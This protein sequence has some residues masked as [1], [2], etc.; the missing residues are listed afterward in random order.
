MALGPG[1]SKSPLIRPNA[2]QRP[3]VEL[4]RAPHNVSTRFS[5]QYRMNW[6]GHDPDGRIDRYLYSI[7]PPPPTTAVPEPESVWVETARSEQLLTFTATQPDTTVR[8]GEKGASDFHTFVLK[9]VD[10]GGLGGPL[11][12]EPLIRSF[13]TYTVAPMVQIIEP[14]PSSR[15]RNYIPPSVRIHWTGDDPDG[16]LHNQKPVQYK[17]IML[18]EE[19]P[20]PFSIA[21]TNPDSVR[22]Y[23]APRNWATWDST[24]ADTLEK[25]YTNLV[26]GKNY[27]F[28]IIAIDEAGAY[29]PVFN[30]NQNMLNMR[31]TFA[32]QGGPTLTV[33]SDIFFYTYDPPVYSTLPQF[34]IK[35]EIP[36]DEPLTINWIAEVSGGAD[37]RG[38]R[39]VLDTDDLTDE[40]PRTNERTDVRHWSQ[41]SALNTSATIGPFGGN[42]THFFY[43]ESVDNN[44]LKSL[45]TV[46]LTVVK[47]TFEKDL[48]VVNDT[49]FPLDER[50]IGEPLCLTPPQAINS[51]WPSS[52]ELDTFLFARGNMPWRCYP[53][54]TRTPPGLF[55][56]YAFDTVSSR[57]GTREVRVPLAILG[58]YRHVVWLTD[59]RAANKTGSGLSLEDGICA[60]RYMND[61]G[62]ANSLAAYI[63]QRGEV[64]L[65][66]GGGATATLLPYNN[67][68]NDIQ[69]TGTT[70]SNLR[71][72]LVPG[73]FMYDVFGLRSEIKVNFGDIIFSKFLG[74]HDSAAVML[75][76]PRPIEYTRVPARMRPKSA[77]LGDAYPPNRPILNGVFYVIN[78]DIEYL[79]LRNDILEDVNPDLLI[80]DEQS[81]LDTL[82]RATGVTLLGPQ[83]NFA[84]VSMTRYV[85]QRYTKVL[86]SGFN[87]WNFAR[88]DCKNLVDAVLQDMWGLTYLPPPI[89]A[90]PSV[91]SYDLRSG[92]RS[93]MGSSDPPTLAGG[94]RAPRER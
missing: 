6:I 71:N 61:F 78:F 38:T 33:F 81:T 93:S 13:Y 39:W 14:R 32:A 25:Q 34:Q 91:A 48:L 67:R 53:S 26:P 73:R 84:N 79:S 4:T 70:F 10:N 56:G 80:V 92:R 60:L 35:V 74:R 41:L 31:T 3:V 44:G 8:Q 94:A 21:D 28:V 72:E 46:R 47:A 11:H 1:C 16:I 36:A 27:M 19:S 5:Y 77:A 15:G 86:F 43:V 69:G 82:F 9:A 55:A 49:R 17:F 90:S 89:A 7:D 58:K 45:A 42:E 23:Y 52:A 40:T 62:R 2:N 64:W 76:R 54:G 18:T 50:R 24:T 85:G 87:I 20:V 75:G 65:A 29:S 57:K 68:D 22:R 30:L 59:S 12:S 63:K 83:Q 37:V 51:R 66:G 88:V